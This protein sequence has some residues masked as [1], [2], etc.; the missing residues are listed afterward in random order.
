MNKVICH[1]LLC[2][3]TS[4]IEKMHGNDISFIPGKDFQEYTLEGSATYQNQTQHPD[5]GAIC[6]ETVTAKIKYSEDLF[7]LKFALEYFVLKLFSDTDEFVVGSIE[8]PA[9]ISYTHDKRFVNLTFKV[10]RPQ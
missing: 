9:K 5:A 3:H 1:R 10:T 6:T 8:Y 4:E 2:T 7:F